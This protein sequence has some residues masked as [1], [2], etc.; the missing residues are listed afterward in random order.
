MKNNLLAINSRGMTKTM[1]RWIKKTAL[2]AMLLLAQQTVMGFSLLGP[3]GPTSDPWQVP[4]IGYDLPG[5]DDGGGPRNLGEEYRWTTPYIYYAFDANFLEYFGSNGVYA[6]ERGIALLNDL[7]NFSSYSKDLSEFPLE[8]QRINTRAAALDLIDLKSATLFVLLE[9]LGLAPAARF[10]WAIRIRAT[11]PT[12][13]CPFMI[14]NIIKRN[15]DPVTWEP[16]SYVNGVL[17]TYQI[18]E[19]CTGPNPLADAIEIPVDRTAPEFTAVTSEAGFG[20]AGVDRRGAYVT[21]LSRDD[22]GGL[23]YLYVTN[24]MNV[25]ATTGDSLEFVTNRSPSLIVSSNLNLLFAQSL[26]NDAATLATLFPGLVV[27]SS[28]NFFTVVATTNFTTVL[29]NHPWDPAGTFEIVLA[30]IVTFSAQTLFSHTFANLVTVQL[31][32]GHYVTVP[33]TDF[34]AS[35]NR[36]FL[37]TE[38]TIVTNAPWSTGVLITNTIRH[39]TLTS[40]PGGEFF[41]LPTNAC[42]LQIISPFLTNIVTTTNFIV[43]ATNNPALTNIVPGGTNITGSLTVSRI[44][45][46]TNHF[47]LA[48]T[49]NCVGGTNSI[50]LREGMDHFKFLRTSYDSL[51][52]RFYQPITNTYYLIEVTNSMPRT[53]WFRRIVTHP[54]FL[55]SAQ[56]LA[57]N[58]FQRTVVQATFNTNNEYFGLAGP[59]NIDPSGLSRGIEID[60]NKVGP[61][62]ENRYDLTLPNNGLTEFTSTTNFI[63]GSFDGT[64]NAPIIYP[65]GTSIMN[66]ESQVFFQIVTPVLADGRVN[67]PY[68][69]SLEVTDGTGP[70]VWVPAP[71]SPPL[72]TGLTLAAIGIV[73]GTPTTPGSFP[74]VVTVT[75][76]ASHISTRTITITVNR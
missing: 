62:L 25:E 3:I 37:T 29:T 61:F 18:F 17:L 34:S 21:A 45:Y 63:W 30:P 39:T 24:N 75:D 69:Q 11:Q 32:D 57:T 8:S 56:D 50:A 68:S 35:T 51:L 46:F 42:D 20:F 66:L 23:R 41:I 27:S 71:G 48:F 5:V 33:I 70:F 59:G 76:A 15:F 47:F 36:L 40:A 4:T 19:S 60:F 43:S 49:I 67:V 74:F 22:V 44:Q 12:R 73:S 16:S 26:T 72:P 1:L 54:D 58:S 38:T 52:G 10:T 7:T 55:F 64:T 14:Y 9:Q 13:S 6:I 31:I 28:S 65:Q 2:L 53:N